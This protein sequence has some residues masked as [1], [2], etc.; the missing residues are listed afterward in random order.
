MKTRDLRI[1]SIRPLMLSQLRIWVVGRRP[2]GSLPTV[3]LRKESQ[4]LAS[5]FTK[6][7]QRHFRGI[8]VTLWLR[9]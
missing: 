2:S 4:V 3:L 9:R 5:D 8:F 7:A 6:V 1:E